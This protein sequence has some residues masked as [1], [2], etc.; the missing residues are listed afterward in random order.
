MSASRPDRNALVFSATNEQVEYWIMSQDQTDK[1]RILLVLA[2]LL[3]LRLSLGFVFMLVW[4]CPDSDKGVQEAA[5]GGRTREAS[6]GGLT[7]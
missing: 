5:A 2:L 1:P 3:V 6:Q 4:L 7:K